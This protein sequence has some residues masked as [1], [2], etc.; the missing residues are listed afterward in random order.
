MSRRFNL[1][2]DAD[3]RAVADMCGYN[4]TGADFYALCSDALL[5][6]MTRT[7]DAVNER[8]GADT[9]SAQGHPYPLTPQ[10]YLD[11]MATE[12]EINV[13]VQLSDFAA[14]VRELVPSV[15]V[16]ELQ[17]YER[18]RDQFQKQ[19]KLE[20]SKGGEPNAAAAKRRAKGKQKAGN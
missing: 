2:P 3:L 7:I 6:A 5:K 20:A 8:L 15:P 12:E 10:Y 4:Y 17:R 18:L 19:D 1:A 13:R 16:D 9:R 14:A 11:Q